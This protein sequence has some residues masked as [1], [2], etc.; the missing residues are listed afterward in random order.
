MP[1][2]KIKQRQERRQGEGKGLWVELGGKGWSYT[3][4]LVPRALFS[5]V[6]IFHPD[7][8]ADNEESG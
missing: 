3:E 6:M 7:I 5:P 8:R 4:A 2:R 1:G